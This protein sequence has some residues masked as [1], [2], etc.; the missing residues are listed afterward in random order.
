LVDENKFLKTNIK[1]YEND[2][3][4]AVQENKEMAI[5]IEMYGDTILEYEKLQRENTH[6]IGLKIIEEDL[7]NK[8]ITENKKLAGSLED[9][10][11]KI[12]L[13]EIENDE[14]I[15]KC[16]YL[17]G[18]LEEE[19][20]KV[21]SY[22]KTLLEKET[23]IKK[24]N[25]ELNSK[26]HK[27]NICIYCKKDCINNENEVVCS[28]EKEKMDSPNYRSYST[29]SSVSCGKKL[30]YQ[31]TLSSLLP[32]LDDDEES[33]IRIDFKV[34]PQEVVRRMSGHIDT[35]LKVQSKANLNKNCTNTNSIDKS[36][37]IYKD[38]FLLTFQ[39]LKLNSTNIEHY[40]NINPLELY[41]NIQ[42]ELIPFHKVK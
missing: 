38:F 19:I 13:L 11:N 15:G 33:S 1:Q 40:L 41:T 23:E 22:R 27:D 12:K 39:S 31:T 4:L 32:E 42:K 16:D 34:T 17:E 37:D 30:N 28:I 18:K 8:L 35:G 24:L 9:Y 2:L 3:N 5:K 14:I 21:K 7:K 6:L 29:V 36:N 25:K 26:D 10:K 20:S